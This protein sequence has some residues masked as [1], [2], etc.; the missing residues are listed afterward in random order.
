MEALQHFGAVD[1]T[2]CGRCVRNL[3]EI[4]RTVPGEPPHKRDC[5]PA[6]R[7]TSIVPDSKFG[8][9]AI[10]GVLRRSAPFSGVAERDLPISP[11]FS[12]TSQPSS[13]GNLVK[14]P[15]KLSSAW[16][17]GSETE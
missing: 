4:D 8:H 3:D 16:S 5:T 15:W 10:V 1:W 2:R 9:A 13:I 12:V 6:K 17:G 7:A 14:V 11:V